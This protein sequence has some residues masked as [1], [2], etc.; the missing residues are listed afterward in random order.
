MD[1]YLVQRTCKVRLF[2][3]IS[4]RISN[5]E[6]KYTFVHC[7]VTHLCIAVVC[8]PYIF[9]LYR[10]L[11]YS[12]RVIDINKTYEQVSKYNLLNGD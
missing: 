2:H 6:F 7:N 11:Y 5:L 3:Y 12:E 4:I 9:N 8:S 10:V 1:T